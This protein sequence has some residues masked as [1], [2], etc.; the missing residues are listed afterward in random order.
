MNGENAAEIRRILSAK[1]PYRTCDFTF[2][3]AL[4]WGDYFD[5]EYCVFRDTVFGKNKNPAFI[6]ENGENG[7]SFLLPAGGLSIDESV[8][9]LIEYARENGEKT[10]VLKS[11][12][13]AAAEYLREKF[14]AKV[15]ELAD[16]GDY[17]YSAESLATLKGHKYN[18]KR[19]R[20]NQ[21]KKNYPNY[22]FENVT[23]E[24]LGKIFEL[25]GK[26]KSEQNADMKTENETAENA[27]T[28]IIE[29]EIKNKTIDINSATKNEIAENADTDIIESEIKDKTIDINSVTKNEI[30][31]NADTDIIES[32]IKN[33]TIDIN[34][35]TKNEIIE[36]TAE[37]LKTTAAYEANQ[38]EKVLNDFESLGLPCRALFVGERAV[39]FTVGEVVGD[40]LYT[41]VEKADK[42]YEG[43]YQMINYL[44]A[45]EMR[46]KFSV[47]YINREDDLGD[48]G[49]RRAKAS[50]YPIEILKK[51]RAEIEIN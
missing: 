49:L 8:G 41:H 24:N 39:A 23:G 19:N 50:Y 51:Y 28:D 32:E 4:F 1:N 9:F 14:G 38:I 34:S 37:K 25:L 26:I 17:L 5:G 12:P 48:A 20:V 44:F 45:E 40:T 22:S 16:F 47:E 33:K 27:D 43:A 11:V 10:L 21:F 15:C 36:S 35:V 18:K 46:A 30:A 7:Y 2:G 6:S 3:I 13:E 42:D 29:S 31:E